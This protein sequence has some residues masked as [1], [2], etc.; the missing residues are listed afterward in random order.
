MNEGIYQPEFIEVAKQF[1][2][3]DDFNE[4]IDYLI[5]PTGS[6]G[7]LGGKSSG[8]ILAH[9]IL[10]D[11]TQENELL[12]DVKTPKTWHIAS[13]NIFYFMSYN[14]LEDIAEQKYKDLGQVRQEYPYVVH[15]FKNAVFQPEIIKGL[16]LALDDFGDV[17]LII[18][19]SSLL[20]DRMGMAFSSA[21]TNEFRWMRRKFIVI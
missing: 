5:Y 10:K 16:S 4:L 15:V 12:R 21:C 19:S 3:V 6:H 14:N 20:E 13:D 1:I 2:Q 8:L 17:P 18:R 7:R 9:Q 11:S